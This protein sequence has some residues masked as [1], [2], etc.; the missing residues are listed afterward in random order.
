MY[1]KLLVILLC[2]F[3]ISVNTYAT[4]QYPDKIIYNGTE[5]DLF[6]NPLEKYFLI[7]PDKRP[8]GKITSTALWRGYIA[9]FEIIDGKLLLKD[10]EIQIS[11]GLF[12]SIEYEWKS[13]LSEFLDGQSYFN[14]DWFSGLLVIPY[15][16]L[17]NY[18]HMGYESTYE[19]YILLEIE[20][21]KFIS[22]KMKN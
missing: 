15:G 1:N 4:A 7:N 8:K 21:G 12:P 22:E 9:T 18:V 14:M 11:T 16:K 19:D 5:Y 10:I 2:L 3:S 20:N 17:I 13:V 6:V